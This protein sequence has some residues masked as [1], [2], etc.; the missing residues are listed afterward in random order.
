MSRVMLPLLMLGL[1][2]SPDAAAAERRALVVGANDGGL[3]LEPLRYAEDDALRVAGLLTELGGFSSDEVT[4]LLAPT[5]AELGAVL[6]EL[7]AAFEPEADDL[8]LFYYSGHADGQGLRLGGEVWTYEELKASIR[9]VPADVHLGIL[10]ACR[11]GAIT[12]VKG[13][14]VTAPFLVED[15]LAARGEAWLAAS[16]ED[17]D[18]QESDH[19]QGS[20]FTHYLVSGLRGAA[21]TG[22]GYVSLGEAY[23][24][25]YERTVARTGATVA[26]AQHPAYDFR[27][28]GNGD[29]RLTEVHSATAAITLP[30]DLV[31]EVAVLR[32]PEGTPVAEVAKA[33]G[34]PVTVALEPGR[35]LLRRRVGPG[36]PVQEVTIT[37]SSGASPVVDRWGDAREP[38]AALSKGALELPELPE[39]PERWWEQPAVRLPVTVLVP[40]GGQI[41]EGDYGRAV[42]FLLGTAALGVAGYSAGAAL[43]TPT[44][45]T[46]SGSN[47]LVVGSLA[48]HG[49]A[50]ADTVNHRQPESRRP[51]RGV[52]VA[53]DTAWS[54][55]WWTPTATGLA[56]DWVFLPTLSVGLDRTG[57]RLEPDDTGELR[58]RFTTGARFM[59][60]PEFKRWKPAAFV[61]VGVG[62]PESEEANVTEVVGGGANLRVYLTPR[63][64]AQYDARWEKHDGWSPGLSQGIG[65]GV[66]LGEGYDDRK[67]RKE[68]ARAEEEAARLAEREA[69]RAQAEAERAAREAQKAAES[70]AREAAEVKEPSA[71][72][73]MLRQVHEA[74]LELLDSLQ[75]RIEADDD[76]AVPAAGGEGAPG[77]D[78]AP[79]EPP[80]PEESEGEPP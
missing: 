37:L 18:A 5:V 47:P 10:D 31:G 16:A 21:D 22:D 61:V 62:T 27:L 35:Y 71:A 57:W 15:G 52:T 74:H 56:V 11:S 72:Q 53:V 36:S 73:E 19:L 7:D 55:S 50:V 41:L 54:S 43:D 68:L 24:Y 44:M 40:G 78:V 63:Y 48:V 26:G 20:F 69:Q 6:S 17:E 80:A 13:A 23:S 25:A 64:F 8:F 4:V 2:A 75:E 32:L 38:D 77:D 30:A 58:P 45:A 46:L 66:H 1:A 76:E 79:A 29:L 51:T 33:A 3:E 70:Q 39:L 14:S 28:S 60:G 65:I 42:F 59:F 34:R 12:R 67:S 49:W 9:A